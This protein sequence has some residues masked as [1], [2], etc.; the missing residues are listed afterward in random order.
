MAYITELQLL[1]S[2]KNPVKSY[3]RISCEVLGWH[4]NSEDWKA[5]NGY[6]GKHLTVKTQM[7]C[8]IRQFIFAILLPIGN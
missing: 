5:L 8:R 7:K 6:C 3:I 1:P 4:V 2:G